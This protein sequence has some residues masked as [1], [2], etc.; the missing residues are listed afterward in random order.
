MRKFS[1]DEYPDDCD[2]DFT[3]DCRQGEA[4]RTQNWVFHNGGFTLKVPLRGI[5][6][7]V[8]SWL[9][10]AWGRTGSFFPWSFC[11][12]PGRT[13]NCPHAHLS[14]PGKMWYQSM[15]ISENDKKQSCLNLRRSPRLWRNTPQSFSAILCPASLSLPSLFLPLLP[16]SW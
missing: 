10:G 8:P 13:S 5:I 3:A 11:L 12:W 4:V 2:D 6:P 14:F 1:Y 15:V 9:S 7:A 16:F